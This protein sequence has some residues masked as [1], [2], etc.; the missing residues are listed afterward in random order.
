MA[1]DKTLRKSRQWSKLRPVANRKQLESF[2]WLVQYSLNLKK[3]KFDTKC[4]VHSF[5]QRYRTVPNSTTRRTLSE[6]IFGRTVRTTL[7]LIRP[8][9]QKQV[10]SSQLRLV[11]NHDRTI[12]DRFFDEGQEVFVRQYLGLLK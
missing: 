12:R 10:L 9:I 5:L 1:F 11:R 4:K 7:D 2:L 3:N 6:L 8:Q